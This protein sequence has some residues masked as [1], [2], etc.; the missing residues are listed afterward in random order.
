MVVMGGGPLVC[1]MS[2]VA[3]AKLMRLG[4]AMGVSFGGLPG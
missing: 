3:N 4:A 1:N 2:G